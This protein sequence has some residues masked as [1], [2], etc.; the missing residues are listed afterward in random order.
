MTALALVGGMNVA[1]AQT[2]VTS[3]YI[4]NADFSSTDGWTQ[5]HSNSNYWALGNGLIGTY[6]IANNKNSTTDA[7]HLS[8]EY[9]LG[10]QC[11]WSTN[12]ANFTQETAELPVGVYTL[13]YD[14]QNTNTSTTS[15][16]Y[17]NRFTVKVGETT[18]TDSKTE[19]M[20]SSSGWTEHTISF[21]IEAAST[22]TISLGYG[23]GS[24]NFGSANTPHLYVSH[25]KLTWTDPNAAANAAT[26]AA[27]KETLNGYIKKATALNSVLSDAALTTA[28]E[29]AQDVYDNATDYATDN[30]GVVSASTT[31]NNAI[32]TALSSATAVALENGTFDTTP[33]NTLNGDGTTTFGGTLSTATSNPDNTKEMTANTGDHGYLYEVTGWTQYSKFNSTASQGTTSEYGTAMPANG[34]S[35]NSTTPP[36]TDMFGGSTG[37]ALHLSAG[38]NDQAR[39]QQTINDLPSGRYVFYYEVINQHSST[40]IASNYT[41]V[42]GAAGDFYGTT[43]RFVYS[44][45]RSAAQ[46]EWIAQAFEFDVAKTANI[47]FNVG[48]TTSTEGSGNGAKLWIDNVLVYRI[49]DLTVT[50]ADAEAILE[51]VAALDDVVY[52]ATDKNTLADAKNTFESNKN[53]DNY[54]ALN[55]A[56][57]AAKASVTVYTTLNTAITNVEGWTAT[58]A[59]ESIRAKYNN[60]EYANETTAANIYSEY[61]ATEMT[62][63]V[64]DE[65]TDFTSVILNPSFETNDMT[66]WS[67]E[68]RND[69]GVKANSDGTYTTSGVDGDY[70]F[71]SWGGTAENNVYQTIK[72]LPAGTYTLTALVAGFNGEELVIA[73][74]ETT[75]KV[76]VAGDKTVG[77]TAAVEFTLSATTDVVIKVSNTKSQ[78]TSDASFIKADNFKL[79][80]GSLTTNDYTALNAAIATVEANTIGFQTGEYAPYKNVDAVKAL[81]AAKAVDQT[82]SILVTQ[83]DDIVNNLTNA[84][85]TANTEEVNAFYDGTFAIQPEHTTGPTALDGW[86]NPQGIRQLIKNTDTYPGL[87]SA[88]DKAAVFAW[89]NTTLEYGKTEGYTMPLA[90][91]TIYEL[92]FKTCGWIDGDMGYVNVTVLNSSNEGLS[93][94]TSATATKRIREENPW[95]EFKVLFETGEAGNYTFSMWTSKHTTFTDLVLKKAVAEV[96]T[97]AEDAT[98]APAASEYANVTLS[99]TLSSSYWN[100]FSVPFDMDIPDGWTVKE[101]VS[102]ED[103]TLNFQ[104]ATSIQAGVPYLVKTEADVV[105]PTFEGVTVEATEG[106]TIGEGDYKFAAQIYNK[107]LATDGTIAYLSTDGT[108]K[109]LT[110]GGLKGLRAYFVLPTS[111]PEGARIAF[112]DDGGTTTGIES[113]ASEVQKVEN[114][115]YDLQGRRVEAMKKGLYI[116]NGKKVV[117]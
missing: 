67:A 62:A 89:G 41:G 104:A 21:T 90:A 117:K 22:A 101:F 108:I 92:T 23:T 107:S 97:I 74:N 80:K 83:L 82:G 18:Y 38:W 11:R 77:Y 50:D 45:L 57:I 14:V 17:E 116:V 24:N 19:W 78:S 115:V 13:T 12:Y 33:N 46:G 98:T 5:N 36:A 63:L 47:S 75:N 66:G 70:L 10:I 44:D 15:A 60:G 55:D 93:Q 59:A 72:N 43:N 103:N 32:T 27:N 58:S 88:T 100:T 25:L 84:T 30:D 26:L 95:D 79:T 51:E 114:G 102:A 99:R 7:T 68:S 69:T 1:L 76:T 87:N 52:N 91:H 110:S 56:L 29:T 8:T 112:I 54:N 94:K 31:L 48:F 96:I 71:N 39:Y 73:A 37:A 64:A 42:G 109:K 65:A 9:C 105:N 20:T 6:A 40:G 4:T 35:T 113:M 81:A 34:W 2:D 61:Q 49:G 3:T 111:T 53:I 85:W 86:N 106:E 16:T 28:I